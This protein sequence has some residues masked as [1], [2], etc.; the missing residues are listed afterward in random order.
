MA[1]NDLGDFR[2]MRKNLNIAALLFVSIAGPSAVVARTDST[3]SK[4]ADL[5]GTKIHYLT[6]GTGNE[7]IV[8]IHG[9]SCDSTVWR[10]QSEALSSRIRTITIDLPGHGQ[11]DKP[12]IDYTMDLYARAIDSVLRNAGVKRAILVGHSNGTPVV[13]QFYRKYPSETA[14]LVLVDGPLR[15]AFKD[16]ASAER[17]LQPLRG[18]KFSDFAGKFI[19]S[20]VAPVKDP[21]LRPQIKAMMLATP[22]YVAFSEFEA[23]LDPAI[24]TEDKINVPVLVI[25]AKKSGGTP[26]YEQY[27]H[28]LIPNVDYRSWEGVSHFLMMDKPKEFNEVLTAFAEKNG[29]AK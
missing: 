1:F 28:T 15:G 26:G 19:D 29:L 9:W 14:A 23:S 17:F 4:F 2:P 7:A 20:I 25:I 11:S 27:V 21:Q 3:H 12:H 18:D 24:W 10:F 16:K 6:Y 8:F 5:D 13:R 22:Q